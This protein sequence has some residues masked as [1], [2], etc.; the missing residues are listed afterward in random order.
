M[1]LEREIGLIRIDEDDEVGG[2]RR[3]PHAPWLVHGLAEPADGERL[4]Q[5]LEI[6]EPVPSDHEVGLAH[7]AEPQGD[8]EMRHRRAKR[9]VD[10]DASLRLLHGA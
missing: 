5:P 7:L 1:P 10:G 4:V 8:G 9:L 3:Q 2:G 6:A